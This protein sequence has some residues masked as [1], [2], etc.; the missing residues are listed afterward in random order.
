MPPIGEDPGA[1]VGFDAGFDAGRT[2]HGSRREDEGGFDGS[3]GQAAKRSVRAG[4]KAPW[5]ARVFPYPIDRPPVFL[6]VRGCG[7]GIE[8]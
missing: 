8:S 6:A 3:A 5:R 4:S 7:S 1:G 2:G